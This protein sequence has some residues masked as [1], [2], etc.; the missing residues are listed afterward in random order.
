MLESFIRRQIEKRT[1]PGNIH[2]GGQRG[3]EILF[4]R[5]FGCLATW[6]ESEPLAADTLFDLASLTKPLVTAFLAV[7]FLD[8]KQWRL[9]DAARR[10]IPG[11]PLAVTLE[12]LLTHSAGFKPWYPF[13]LYR[14]QDDLAPDGHGRRCAARQP[15][16]LL[17][18]R[19]HPAAPPP[20]KGLRG[21][22]PGARRAS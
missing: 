4:D 16:R 1:F 17:R 13:Y 5:R 7:Y 6:P 3:D 8:R 21:R 9:D 19:L 11:F 2:P 22:F 10:F 14:P 12:Q 20:G 18:R 15:G